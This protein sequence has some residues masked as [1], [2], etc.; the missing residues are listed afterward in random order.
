MKSVT[1]RAFM[2]KKKMYKQPETEVLA[3]NTEYMMQDATVSVN[4]GGGGGG[5]A[6]APGRSNPVPDSPHL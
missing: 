4:T 2:A 1:N 3:I 5:T 6:H